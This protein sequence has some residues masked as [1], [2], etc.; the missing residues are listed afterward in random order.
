[1]SSPAAITSSRRMPAI[2]LAHGAPPLLDD[3]VW[4]RELGAWAARL[5]RPSSVLVLSAHWEARPVAI[6]ATS[7]VPLVY[8]FYGFPQRYYRMTYASPGAP[9]L[10]A[11]VRDVL[12][13]KG[14]AFTEDPSR[15][16]DHGAW[17]PLVPMYP[18]ADVPVL[19]VSLP[20]LD[21]RELFALGQALA[22]LRDEGVLVMGSGF[23]THNMASLGAPAT[24]GWA[25]AFDGW[26]GAA[27]VRRDVDA[28][29]DFRARAP[30]ARIAHPREEHFAPVLSVLGSASDADEKVSF[31]ITGFWA[32]AP[33]F[34][35]RSVQFG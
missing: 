5:P 7:L 19:Q 4:V 11:R 21:T 17:V 1:M 8:D 25:A 10:A 29:L 12:R 35:R 18:N 24:P 32:M 27:L 6:G 14:I 9:E 31:P 22:P 34:T 26:V 16:L 15:G 28:L 20:S 13:A 23:L 33:S 3:D 2:F 30:D